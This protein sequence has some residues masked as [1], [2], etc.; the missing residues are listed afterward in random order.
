MEIGNVID[1]ESRIGPTPFYTLLFIATC[2]EYFKT[3][4]PRESVFGA[5]A[6]VY[7]RYGWDGRYTH[8]GGRGEKGRGGPPFGA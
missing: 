3:A 1:P 4:L 6:T 7:L 5:A 8:E 2:V